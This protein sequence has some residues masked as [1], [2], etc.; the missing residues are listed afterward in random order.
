MLNF[1]PPNRGVDLVDSDLAQCSM[2]INDDDHGNATPRSAIP[3]PR[4]PQW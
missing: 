4:R 1:F 2:L 3:F